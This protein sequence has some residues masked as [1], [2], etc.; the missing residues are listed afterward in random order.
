M[1]LIRLVNCADYLSTNTSSSNSTVMHMKNVLSVPAMVVLG[2]TFILAAIILI[3]LVVSHCYKSSND[4]FYFNVS[5]T[6]MMMAFVCIM[7]FIP[8]DQVSWSIYLYFAPAVAILRQVWSLS[9]VFLMI[10]RYKL[11]QGKPTFTIFSTHVAISFAWFVGILQGTYWTLRAPDARLAYLSSSPVGVVFDNIMLLNQAV[12]LPIVVTLLVLI[13][14][15]A[16]QHLTKIDDS[17][18]GE[19]VA[20][21]MNSDLRLLYAFGVVYILGFGL[22]FVTAINSIIDLS[23][24][25]DLVP[26]WEKSITFCQY[27]Y[28]IDE[29]GNLIINLSNSL[30]IVRTRHV[31]TALKK[32]HHATSK[33]VSNFRN[34]DQERLVR[35]ENSTE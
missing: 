21:R 7:M 14:C 10:N 1:T 30:I 32:M 11:V 12:P 33:V 25:L 3:A 16:R 8:S 20:R 22:E 18:R 27:L 4:I 28:G 29:L 2:G 23:G 24:Y 17:H 15:K 6:D 19:P 31:Q 9:I 26:H 34:G 35:E 13:V 5:L